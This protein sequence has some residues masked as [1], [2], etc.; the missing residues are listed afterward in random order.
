[1]DALQKIALG[2]SLMCLFVALMAI[3]CERFQAAC[4]GNAKAGSFHIDIECDGTQARETLR[5][6]T[7][8][9]ERLNREIERALK[10]GPKL[11]A[12]PVKNPKQT[13]RPARKKAAPKR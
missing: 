12:L 8:D 5:Q 2:A 1:M 4:R 13:D 3:W 11:Q 9:A 10:A 6:L 7:A